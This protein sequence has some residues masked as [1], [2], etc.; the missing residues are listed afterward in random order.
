VITT[1][2]FLTVI[3]H[4]DPYEQPYQIFIWHSNPD[5]NPNPDHNHNPS[6]NSNPTPHPNRN[7]NLNY[8]VNSTGN[9]KH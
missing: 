1:V 2:I 5:A 3:I 6:P 8:S 7:S 9:S 4:T